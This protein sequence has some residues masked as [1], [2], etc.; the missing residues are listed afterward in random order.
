MADLEKS[1]ITKL[2]A[3]FAEKKMP[4][5][6][7]VA[8]SGGVDSMALTFLLRG[9]CRLKKI[10]LIALTVDHKMR[11]ISDK[12][13]DQVAEICAQNQIFHQ[14]LE[15]DAEN[16]PRSNVESVLRSLRYEAL[17][18]FCVAHKIEFLFLG[19]QLDD[20]AEN[21]LIRLFRGSGLDG[22]SPIAEI[23]N[24]KNLNLV[25]PLLS[26]AKDDL[27]EFLQQQ[28][29]SW[30]EDETN[31]DEK[32]LRNKIRNFLS[33]FEDKNLI[34]NRIRNAALEISEMRDFFDE[35]MILEAK[36]VI[37]FDKNGYFLLKIDKIKHFFSKNDTK[38][39]QIISK[40]LS[41]VLVEV[42]GDIYKPRREKLEQILNWIVSDKDHKAK[43]FDGCIIEKF[44]EENLVIYRELAAINL[45]KIE[46]FAQNSWLIDGRFIFFGNEEEAKNLILPTASDLKKIKNLKGV[47]KKIAAT[48]PQKKV[49]EELEK[50]EL[51]FYFRTVL[52]QIAN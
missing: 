41:L 42:S 10:E 9:F 6:V 8:L 39:R 31:E 37:K 49:G 7:A 22:L 35:T 48:V 32:F 47:V 15:I 38:N 51:E 23:S 36:N 12:E 29:I 52:Q 44:D 27:R 24:Y 3:I 17:H 30:F 21:F 28:N 4:K 50:V 25:R 14:I 34:Q 18:Q 43:S 1:F 26:V 40:I 19:H 45:Q 20:I 5:K 2:D 33:S 16:L 46:K 11:D 13:A